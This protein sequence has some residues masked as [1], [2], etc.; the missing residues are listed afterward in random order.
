MRQHGHVARAVLL[1]SSPDRPGLVAAIAGAVTGAG[2]NILDVDSHLED[3]WFH[4]RLEAEVVGADQAG[5]G[6]DAD[7]DA[8]AT[9][10]RRAAVVAGLDLDRTRVHPRPGR[11]VPTALLVSRSPHCAS[12]LLARADAGSLPIEVRL[13]ASNHV[14]LAPLAT[15]WDVPFAHVPDEVD[16]RAAVEAAGADLV[17]LARYMRILSEPTCAA[18]AG[19]AINIHHS[20]LPAFVGADPYR[21][22]HHRGVKMIGATAHYVTGDLDAGP[23]IAQDTTRVSHRD[24]VDELRRRGAELERRVLADAVRLH[25]DDRVVIAG[26]RTVVFDH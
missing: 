15:R 17:V 2:L 26:D 24:T 12:D 19:R 9:A 10:L 11:A 25:V 5:T 6:G 21:R 3:G 20:F 22:A 23:I 14:D 1:T 4:Q 7:S 18:W 13:V 8:A 16:L